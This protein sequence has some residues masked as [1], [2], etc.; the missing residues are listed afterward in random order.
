MRYTLNY[1]AKDKSVKELS[2]H[3][4]LTDAAKALRTVRE[5]FGVHGWIT[6]T[7][8]YEH[9]AEE[10]LTDLLGAELEETQ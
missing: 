6:D 7:F 1:L 10:Y 5:D 9:Y 3:G 4:N 2:A 8:D